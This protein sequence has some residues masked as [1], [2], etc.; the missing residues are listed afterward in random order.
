MWYY[1]PSTQSPAFWS[2]IMESVIRKVPP[3]NLREIIPSLGPVNYSE[4]KVQKVCFVLPS[5]NLRGGSRRRAREN[6]I[7]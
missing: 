7:L 4:T 3:G 5:V 2:Y 1:N 6:K